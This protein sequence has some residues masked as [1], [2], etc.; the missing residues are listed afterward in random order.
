[1]WYDVSFVVP[2]CPSPTFTENNIKKLGLH[3]RS[4]DTYCYLAEMLMYETER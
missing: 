3:S 1:M 2:G 4:V